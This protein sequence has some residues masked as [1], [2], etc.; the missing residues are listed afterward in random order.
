MKVP[1]DPLLPILID[2][3]EFTRY[4]RL[5]TRGYDVYSPHRVIFAHDNEKKMNDKI[6]SHIGLSLHAETQ[7]KYEVDFNEWT[8][9]GINPGFRRQVYDD[10][11][12]RM[13]LLLGGHLEKNNPSDLLHQIAS[14]TRYGL[15]GKRSLDQFID[16]TGIDVRG[17]ASVIGDRCK[18]LNWITYSPEKD[19]HV[20][21][22]DSWGLAPELFHQNGLDIPILRSDIEIVTLARGSDNQAQKAAIPI[23]LT[24]NIKSEE[25]A[26][27]ID[28]LIASIDGMAGAGKG[29]Q[30]LKVLLLV[31]P[32]FGGVVGTA[33]WVLLG[34][35]LEPLL[36]DID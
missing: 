10:A 20:D 32:V 4:A 23:Q 14:L 36:T 2:G 31:M 8:R 3:Q 7:K 21:S 35:K 22:T 30:V 28:G 15:G 24:T 6:A 5:W 17:D 13:I 29:K 11:L 27:I 1:N 16:F 19:P 18:A 26:T 33:L 25:S 34:G 12:A 9:N